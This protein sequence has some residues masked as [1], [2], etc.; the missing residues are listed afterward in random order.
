MNKFLPFPNERIAVVSITRHGIALAGRVIASLPGAQLYASD[1]FC[2]EAEAAAPG[3]AICYVGKL[4]EQIPALFENFDGIVA[5]VPLG[6][7]VRMMVP[8]LKSKEQDPGV[9]L[10]DGAGHYAIPVLAGHLGG[11]NALAGYLARALGM[12][13]VLTTASDVRETLAVDLLGR[14]LGWTLDASRQALLRASAAVVNEEPVAL[15]QEAGSRDWWAQHANGRSNAL[16]ANIRL[17]QKIEELDPS[18]YGAVLWITRRK[19]DALPPALYE[20][21]RDRLVVYTPPQANTKV[22]LGI[23]CDSGTPFDTIAQAADAALEQAGVNAS[24][25]GAV[26]SIDLKASEPGL[27][28]FAAARGWQ[29]KF[30]P[31]AALSAVAVPNPSEVV[32]KYTGTP[33]VSEAAALL[34]ARADMSQMLV[35]KYKLRGPDGRNATVSIPR[36]AQ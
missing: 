34:A 10:L 11:A 3:T 13:P 2:A 7:M 20:D 12:L 23:G 25:V 26:A 28:Q 14:E 16:P 6:A 31:A 18:R 30:Y 19:P 29:I 17:L 4:G 1:K 22:A 15:V 27:L 32:R 5:I 8:H 35:E 36:S 33:S 9:V 24:D 21:I